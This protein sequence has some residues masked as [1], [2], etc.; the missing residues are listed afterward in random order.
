MFGFVS[1]SG[2]GRAF[3]FLLDADAVFVN[4]VSTEVAREGNQRIRSRGEGSSPGTIPAAVAR[5]TRCSEERGSTDVEQ[6]VNGADAARFWFAYLDQ[7]IR[8]AMA[9]SAAPARPM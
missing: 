4:E 2:R 9:E 6:S 3:A 8:P 7:S 5:E 1:R